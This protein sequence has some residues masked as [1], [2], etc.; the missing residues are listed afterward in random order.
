MFR[1]LT[2]RW[3]TLAAAA[4]LL[5]ALT[6]AVTLAATAG[7][8]PDSASKVFQ[9]AACALSIAAAATTIWG[10]GLAISACLSILFAEVG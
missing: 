1:I 2:W 3:P 7:I 4:L 8:T 10:L 6:S 9:Y 5:V